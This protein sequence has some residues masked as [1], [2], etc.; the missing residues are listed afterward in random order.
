[1]DIDCKYS[2]ININRKSNVD[3]QPT[4]YDPLGWYDKHAPGFINDDEYHLSILRAAPNAKGYDKISRRE[5]K[6]GD[7]V[8]AK[9][10]FDPYRIGSSS[11]GIILQLEELMVIRS[12][13]DLVTL[14]V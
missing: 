3:A 11:A 13:G 1:M 5:L 9:V 7:I 4:S 8:Q 14:K 12:A 2:H 10:S 6:K